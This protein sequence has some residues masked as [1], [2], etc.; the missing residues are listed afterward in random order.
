MSVKK[1]RNVKKICYVL[2]WLS[3]HTTLDKKSN[4]LLVLFSPDIKW[5]EKMNGHLMASCLRNIHTKNYYNLIIILK[6]TIE[7]VGDVF[8][9]NNMLHYL[10]LSVCLFVSLLPCVRFCLHMCRFVWR[11]CR[12]QYFVYLQDKKCLII[13]DQSSWLL[14]SHPNIS[15]ITGFAHRPSVCTSS[16]LGKV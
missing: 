8:L 10:C 2:C 5:G 7:N 3:N 14:C 13:Y 4:I 16:K 15:H 11:R 6:I 1:V 12:R 9:D